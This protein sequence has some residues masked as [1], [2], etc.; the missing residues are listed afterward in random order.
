MKTLKIIPIRTQVAVLLFLS[1]V[2]TSLVLLVS[3]SIP[4]VMSTTDESWIPIISVSMLL[5]GGYVLDAIS[6]NRLLQKISQYRN[7]QN[8]FVLENKEGATIIATKIRLLDEKF[9]CFGVG[10]KVEVRVSEIVR[11][12]H[13][14]RN[15]VTEEKTID[16]ILKM[17]RK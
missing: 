14:T 5:I 1:F 15:S 16:F 17:R 6:V 4:L 2:M 8:Y 10:F 12:I 9:E 3:Y 13:V 7:F 11:I